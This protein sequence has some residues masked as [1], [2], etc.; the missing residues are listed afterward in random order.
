MIKDKPITHN[1]GE[2]FPEMHKLVEKDPVIIT[3]YLFGSYARGKTTPLSD[4]D[5]AVLLDDSVSKEDYFDKELELRAEFSGILKTDEIDLVVLNQA[6]H[7]LAYKVISDGKVLFCRDHQVRAR[8]Q[9]TIQC[10]IDIGNHLIADLSLKTPII[11][12]VNWSRWAR[13]YGS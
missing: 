1:V 11:S 2:L 8:F 6:P 10:C 13:Y 5:L 9:V 7:T 12:G 4:V 3:L